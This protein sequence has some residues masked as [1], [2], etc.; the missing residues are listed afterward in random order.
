MTKKVAYAKA[1]E[2]GANLC[3]ACTN[4][5]ANER[6]T[7]VT[8]TYFDWISRS[9]H[10]MHKVLVQMGEETVSRISRGGIPQSF[11]HKE[12]VRAIIELSF[13]EYQQSGTEGMWELFRRH[14]MNFLKGRPQ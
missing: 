12:A 7:N 4:A 8:F 3:D 5:L 10:S 1:R 6:T 11:T 2:V 13:E 14:D 9:I